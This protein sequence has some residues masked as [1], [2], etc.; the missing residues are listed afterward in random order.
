MVKP[1]YVD[2]PKNELTHLIDLVCEKCDVPREQVMGVSRTQEVAHARWLACYILRNRYKLTLYQ[3]AGVMDK[4]HQTVHMG[5]GR[6]GVL[7]RKDPFYRIAL[8]AINWTL[9][10]DHSDLPNPLRLSA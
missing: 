7:L 10:Q 9:D 2:V 4:N 5:L 3:I 8:E 1:I 6:F